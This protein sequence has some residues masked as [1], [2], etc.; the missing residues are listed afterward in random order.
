MA[1]RSAR[2]A[3]PDRT[4][5]EP[6]QLQV[7]A[8]PLRQEILDLL[9][10]TG[11]A[12]VA[13]IASLLGRPADSLYYHLRELERVGLVV[14]SRARA[15][16]S[17]GEMLFRAAQREPTLFH[18]V[19]SPSNTSAVESIVASMLRLG[20]RDFRNASAS[21]GVCTHGP[22]RELWALRVTG[23]LDPSQVAEI[24]RRIHD[25]KD[26]VARPRSR[27]KLYA[28]TILLTPLTH[29]TRR[30]P[31]RRKPAGRSRAR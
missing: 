17:R 9:A 20:I 22:R 24:N 28:I 30:K 14:S 29:R 11:A 27:G 26:A 7:L 2:S 23:W 12:Q 6:A 5:S 3:R 16:G 1:A 21:D 8:S 19:S 18:D 13:E 25:L 10:R 31:Q 4:I 15:N